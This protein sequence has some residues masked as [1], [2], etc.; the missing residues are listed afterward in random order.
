MHSL[1][2]G[3]VIGDHTIFFAGPFERLELTHRA[4]S[5]ENFAS[6]AVRGAKWL[7]QNKK[8]PGL[9]TMA[10]VLGL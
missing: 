4:H 6:G 7:L 9:Y 8:K 5:R 1:R 2:A 10:Q 3:D